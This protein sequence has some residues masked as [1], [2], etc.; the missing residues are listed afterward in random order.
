MHTRTH[1]HTYTCTYLY[2]LALGTKLLSIDERVLL[3]NIYILYAAG[4]APRIRCR[5]IWR[6]TPNLFAKPK[7]II[8]RI[9]RTR[10]SVCIIFI[11]VRI[12]TYQKTTKIR[13]IIHEKLIFQTDDNYFN[14]TYSCSYSENQYI[15]I[16]VY[17]DDVLTCIVVPILNNIFVIFSMR[18]K[19]RDFVRNVGRYIYTWLW[20]ILI[21]IEMPRMLMT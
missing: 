2:E 14:M 7:R 3:K 4:Q 5:R 6:E 21:I 19:S 12:H 1:S 11:T 8:M 9:M 16:C 15:Y 13:I 18:G 20:C 10:A 17:T